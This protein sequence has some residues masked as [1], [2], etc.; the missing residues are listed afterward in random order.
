M[1]GK[2]DMAKYIIKIPVCYFPVLTD[3]LFRKSVW[4]WQPKINYFVL[5]ELPF[6]HEKGV[7]KPQI[8][9]PPARQ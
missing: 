1:A 2:K 4:S 9:I 8:Q 3:I 5:D 6:E 7:N